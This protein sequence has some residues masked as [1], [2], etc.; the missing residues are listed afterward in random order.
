MHAALWGGHGMGD[1]PE[2][3]RGWL[4]PSAQRIGYA[5]KS[6]LYKWW[7]VLVANIF[8]TTNLGAK[9]FLGHSALYKCIA[10]NS[11]TAQRSCLT[12]LSYDAR[13]LCIQRLT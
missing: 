4:L 7:I 12:Q 1:V 6:A 9:A 5:G 8:P 11:A 10:W 2:V 13:T 3:V